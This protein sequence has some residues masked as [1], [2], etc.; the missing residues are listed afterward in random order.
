MTVRSVLLVEDD[1]EQQ[2]LYILVLA[3]CYQLV[4]AADSEYAL[5]LLEKHRVELVLTDWQ[6]PGMSGDGLIAEI[7]LRFPWIKTILM[8]TD[9]RVCEVAGEA[10]AD[11]WYRKGS[12][13]SHLR[14][15]IAGMLEKSPAITSS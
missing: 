9:A 3:S 10:G 7:H 1:W 5:A 4:V 6:L 12:A 13:I 15:T 14:A 11:G 8:S 2:Q